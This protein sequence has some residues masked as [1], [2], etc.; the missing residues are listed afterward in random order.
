MRWA[1]KVYSYTMS[2]A[3]SLY[4]STVVVFLCYDTILIKSTDVTL[5][6]AAQAVFSA[7]WDNL[8]YLAS[9]KIHCT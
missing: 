3:F 8:C 6:F 7:L 4:V 9:S 1:A 2:L 5:F